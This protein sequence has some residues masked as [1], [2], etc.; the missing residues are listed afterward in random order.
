MKREELSPRPV[1]QGLSKENLGMLNYLLGVLTQPANRWDGFYTPQS[2]SMNFALR[3]QLAFATYAVAQMSQ[4][5]PAYRA[6]Y[7]EAMRSAIRRMLDV[8]V[9]GY[10]RASA[11][12]EEQERA[13]SSGHAAILLNTH[14]RLPAGPP[15]DPIARDNLQYSGHLSTMLG[16]YA[17][18]S[19]V[20]TYNKAFTLQDPVSGVTFRYTYS[21]VAER[22]YSQM[23]RNNFG[24]VC[25]EPGMAYVPCNNYA[26]ASNTLHDALFSTRYSEANN[27]WLDTVKRKLVLKGPAARGVFGTAYMKDFHMATPIAFN[28]TDVWGMS[29]LMPFSRPLVRKLYG[30]MKSKFARAGTGSAYVGSS[31]V[32]ERME[33]S[34]VPINTAFGLLLARGM[35]DKELGEAFARYARHMF[36]ACWDGNR[37][38][39]AAAPRTLQTT[40]LYAL[41][42]SVEWGGETFAQLFT[43]RPHRLDEPCLLEAYDENGGVG[44]TRAYY[45][46]TE[47]S[48][49][50]TLCILGEADSLRPTGPVQSR[51][52]I[53]NLP[54]KPVVEIGGSPIADT[55]WV[56]DAGGTLSFATPVLPEKET[57]CVV[58]MPV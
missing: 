56:L 27:A 53:G 57:K 22:I 11:E 36:G 21:Q 52:K 2:A 37:Y 15:T 14:N 55:D 32:S 3:Y 5:T 50:F 45:D 10:W 28:F 13:L 25:C 39:Y 33:I 19:G 42:S 46:P 12:G 47:R 31:N 24:G 43:G 35:A 38:S 7:I 29:F 9:W 17:R 18:L 30:K 1:N 41:A 51:V 20:D 6:P 40:A 44:V 4:R 49:K 58:R 48:L 23:K 26:M 54:G 8:A 34:D 16:L